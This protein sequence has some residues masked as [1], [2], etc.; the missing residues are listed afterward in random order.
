MEQLS[1]YLSPIGL[2]SDL[3]GVNGYADIGEWTIGERIPYLIVMLVAIVVFGVIAY[4]LFENRPVEAIGKVLVFKKI[5][6]LTRYLACVPL[7]LLG[8]YAFMLCSKSQKSLL[9][10]SIGIVVVALVCDYILQAVYEMSFRYVKKSIICN[11]LVLC[12]SFFV[13]LSFYYDWWHFDSYVPNEQEVK[14]VAISV[15]GIDDSTYEETTEDANAELR[16]E[17]MV[18]SGNA[19]KESIE[20]LKAI[21]ENQSSKNIISHVSV[22]LPP[23]K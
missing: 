4:I 23:K 6:V 12:T 15:K 20:W 17:K 21:A 10:L 7:A 5:E 8:G 11:V 22:A 9:T 1:R 13:A 2:Y 3:L 14:S 19:K 16:M 18:L